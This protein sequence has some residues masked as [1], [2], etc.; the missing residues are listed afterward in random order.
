MFITLKDDQNPHHKVLNEDLVK[1]YITK[2]NH[3]GDGEKLLNELLMV[4]R[5]DNM[6]QNPKFTGESLKLLDKFAQQLKEILQ[7]CK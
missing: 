1:D 7:A 4:G 6:A 3:V 5:A 2:Y